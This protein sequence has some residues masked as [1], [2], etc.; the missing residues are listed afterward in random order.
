MWQVSIHPITTPTRS[1]IR[2]RLSP[3]SPLASAGKLGQD[4]SAVPAAMSPVATVAME[5]ISVTVIS[6]LSVVISMV[7]V[8]TIVVVVQVSG[9]GVEG[10]VLLAAKIVVTYMWQGMDVPYCRLLQHLLHKL[11]YLLVGILQVL[12][13]GKIKLPR[14]GI[15]AKARVSTK[16]GS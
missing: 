13:P 3:P 1:I 12:T 6:M 10:T 4:S 9:D 15:F 2:R 14:L 5:S 16:Q 11:G 7:S 8:S